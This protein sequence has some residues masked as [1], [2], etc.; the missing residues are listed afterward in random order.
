MAFVLGG[1]SPRALPTA[2]AVLA[3]VSAFEETTARLLAAPAR[4]EDWTRV[5]MPFL[6]KPEVWS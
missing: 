5:L 2:A 6:E 4:Q 3:K 1:L